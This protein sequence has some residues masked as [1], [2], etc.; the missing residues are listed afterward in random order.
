[1]SSK[2]KEKWNK[3]Y[4]EDESSGGRAACDWLTSNTETLTGNGKALDIAMGEGRNSIYL[5]QLGF[6][7]TGI[8]I[9]EVGVKKALALAEEKNIEI[10]PIIAD[11][12]NYEFKDDSFDLIVCFY[13]LDRNLF[14]KIKEMVCPGGL[15]VYETFSIDYLKYSSLKKEWVL[16]SGELLKEFREYRIL[17]YQEVDNGQKGFASIIAQKPLKG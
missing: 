6:E 12:D 17:R 9:S 13:F 8:D 10:N 16:D 7:V 2:D 15:V 1:M 4:G 5:A 11:L 14:P 3:K